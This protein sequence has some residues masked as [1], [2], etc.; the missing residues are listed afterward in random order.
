MRAVLAIALVLTACGGAAADPCQAIEQ[1]EALDERF[2]SGDIGTAIA[3]RDRDDLTAALGAAGDEAAALR[4]ELEGGETDPQL[5]EAAGLFARGANLLD[6]TFA[7][8]TIRQDDL[9]AAL[10][11]LDDARAELRAAKSDADCG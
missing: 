7:A 2:R 6:A 3:D 1:L 4:D 11:Y 9:D 10:D 5:V 8:A